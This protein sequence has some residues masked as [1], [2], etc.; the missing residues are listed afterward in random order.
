MRFRAEAVEVRHRAVRAEERAAITHPARAEHQQRVEMPKRLG[1]RRVNGGENGH[2]ALRQRAHHLHHIAGRLG[3]EPAGGF[4]EEEHAR[5]RDERDADVGAFGLTAGDASRER[6]SDSHVA[7]RG[8]L[9]ELQEFVDVRLAHIRGLRGVALELSLV[10]EGLADGEIG[11]ERVV[12][13]DVR[14]D[15]FEHVL[16]GGDALGTQEDAAG[17]LTGGLAAGDDVQEGGLPGAGGTHQRGH[18]AGFEDGGDVAKEA[19]AAA[20][21]RVASGASPRGTDGIAHAVREDAEA[22]GRVELAIAAVLVILADEHGDGVFLART[23]AGKATRRWASGGVAE[24]GR[25][26]F[27]DRGRGV[28]GGD[29]DDDVR[30]ADARGGL[31]RTAPVVGVVERVGRV[32]SGAG[33]RGV[34]AREA[35][36]ASSSGAS[37][38][39]GSLEKTSARNGRFFLQRGAQEAA[40]FSRGSRPVSARISPRPR[41]KTWSPPRSTPKPPPRRTRPPRPRA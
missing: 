29:G 14:G 41:P 33:H 39:L 16:G 2:A 37:R 30:E 12:L 28:D 22:L 27:E 20:V 6:V 24:D 11:Q 35:H 38:P 19:Q 23:R 40:S 15:G 25:L 10:Q 13:L 26:I 18:L 9:E 7:T 21:V 36:S 17:D 31:G 1:R 3:V 32:G 8:E 34:R 4:V 5:T